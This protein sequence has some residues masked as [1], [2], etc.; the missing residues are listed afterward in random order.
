M[1]K[2]CE[3]IVNVLADVIFGKRV[4]E[5]E[6]KN[7]KDEYTLSSVF[8]TTKVMSEVRKYI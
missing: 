8:P 3:K 5:I 6:K 2:M 4:V 7:T 1:G